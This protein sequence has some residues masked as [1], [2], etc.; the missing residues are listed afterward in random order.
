MALKSGLFLASIAV[1]VSAAAFAQ[2]TVNP[3]IHQPATLPQSTTALDVDVKELRYEELEAA[4]DTVAAG[5]E[6]DYFAGVLANREGR[7]AE[8]IP[9]LQRSLPA[10]K[11]RNPTRTAVAL[12]TLADDYVKSYRYADATATYQELLKH[13]SEQ[14]DKVELQDVEDGYN[15]ARLLQDAPPQSVSIDGP[16]RVPTHRSSLGTIDA[17]LTVNG[18]KASWVLDTGANF[19]VV[20]ASFARRL[21]L[22]ISKEEAQTQGITGA[23][24][25]LH[26]AILP[27]L[28]LGAASVHNVVLL[29]LDDDSLELPAG[30]FRRYRIDAVLGYPVFEALGR[31]TFTSDGELDA[32]V[33][34]AQATSGGR[35]FMNEMTP[36]LE[37]TV[38]GRK[39][40]FSFDTGAARSMFFERYYREFS[41]IFVSLKKESFGI[42]GAGGQKKVDTYYLRQAVFTVGEAE[43]TLDRVPVMTKPMGIILE[44]CY[45]NLGRDLM[46]NFRSVTIDFANMRLALGEKLP[47]KG[48][49]RK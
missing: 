47:P 9:L 15:T 25:H 28:K 18:V 36:L 33:A 40:L 43:A 39:L 4:L 12:S 17:E 19:S 35:L 32:G 5:A 30:A 21:R 44:K 29:V 6:H 26:V 48:T 31:I 14:L 7:A 23:E 3:S 38:S 27:E 45:G 2:Q 46:G 34:A 24:N 37:S 11:T 8:S 10:I 49:L 42:A 41:S 13:F 1:F 20:T 22:Q 16:V